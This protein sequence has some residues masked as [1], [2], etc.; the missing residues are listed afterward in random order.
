MCHSSCGPPASGLALTYL[1]L[2]PV[3]SGRP[4]RFPTTTSAVA[5]L[6]TPSHPSRT[7]GRMNTTLPSLLKQRKRFL[8]GGCP[9]AAV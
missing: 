8:V 9:S 5:G 3:T 4:I 2:P 6:S 1:G 7:P